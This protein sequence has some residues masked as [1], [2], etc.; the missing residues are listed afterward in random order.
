MIDCK[1]LNFLHRYWTG[2]WHG[3][4]R[5]DETECP[6]VAIQ[7][8]HRFNFLL[9]HEE[10]VAR[11]DDIPA[12]RIRE[13]KRNIDQFNQKRNNSMEEIDDWILGQLEKFKAAPPQAKLHSE[14]PGMMV[15]RLSIMA[16]KEYHMEEQTRRL[17][18]GSEHI[19]SCSAKL[20][21]LAE[22]QAD[23]TCCLGEL[24]TEISTGKKKFKLYRQLKMYNDPNL[25]P[26]IYKRNFIKL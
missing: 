17:D 26:Q 9:W 1:K 15:D 25:N 22:Q 12:E 3:E 14:T 16:L 13:A 24:L 21:I 20:Q 19:S 2:E 8:N 18:V 23:L 6:W 5:M 7:R 10:D 4:I 11:R